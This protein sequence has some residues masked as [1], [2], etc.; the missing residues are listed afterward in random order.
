M[1]TKPIKM[2][3]L[4]SLWIFQT[5]NKQDFKPLCQKDNVIEKQ[6][7]ATDCVADPTPCLLGV[8]SFYAKGRRGD[9]LINA[10]L[11]DLLKL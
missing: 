8:H 11:V 5:P 10:N 1:L 7:E 6:D 4:L 3:K 9:V 2:T